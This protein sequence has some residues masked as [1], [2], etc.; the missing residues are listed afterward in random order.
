MDIVLGDM[1]DDARFAPV[2]LCATQLLRGDHFA[3]CGLHQRRPTQENRSLIANDYRLVGHRWHVS[4]A[5]GTGPHNAGD[6]RYA[7]GRHLCL[8]VKDPAE[9]VSIWENLRLVR[10]VGAA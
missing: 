10:Q 5:G 2:R 4:A 9:M 8:V 1:V 6:L 7:L 3:R